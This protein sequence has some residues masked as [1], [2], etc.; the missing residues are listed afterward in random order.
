MKAAVHT[1]YGPPERL[2][3]TE[4]E[5]PVPRDNELLV[6]VHA[7][8]V[9]RTDCGF[10]R[11]T[12]FVTRFFSGL[13]KPKQTII[14]EEFAGE[15]K[16]VGKDVTEFQVGDRVFGYDSYNKAR[17]GTQAEYT[18]IDTDAAVTTIPDGLSF[19][20]AAPSNEGV[21]YAYMVLRR[22]DITPGTNVL[23]N[24]A[25]GGIG[26][27]AVQL[28]EYL[29]AEVVAV[30]DED[31]SDLV[32]SLGADHIIDY[33][34]EDFT[35]VADDGTFDVV[36]DAVGKSSFFRCRRLLKPGGVFTATELG[37]Y[38]SNPLLALWTA[39]FGSFRGINVLFPIP[40]HSKEDIKFFKQLI[41]DENFTPVIDRTYP[42]EDIVEAYRYVE[43]GEKT[44]NV[45]ITIH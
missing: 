15:V 30:C 3:V 4:V 19:E 27:A 12:P 39:V 40:S 14:G 42:L 7:A 37:P 2:T 21:H 18:V 32:R 31:R 13:L 23:I 5:K 28:C 45:V 16:A 1:K 25:T 35:E 24:G 22:C 9:T 8:T 43:K 6:K 41:V 29:G 36:F 17:I 20:D 26:S 44:G 38:L 33:T 34:K 10:L 11:A